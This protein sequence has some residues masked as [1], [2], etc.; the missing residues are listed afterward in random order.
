MKTSWRNSIALGLGGFGG[1]GTLVVS[2][3]NGFP[4]LWFIDVLVSVLI[5]IA[6]GQVAGLI[7]DKVRKVPN[8]NARAGTKPASWYLK[9]ISAS[10]P[11]AD[12]LGQLIAM[13]ETRDI[14]EDDF[15]DAKKRLLNSQG[16]TRVAPRP[17]KLSKPTSAPQADESA[18]SPI[19]LPSNASRPAANDEDAEVVAVAL[20]RVKALHDEGI[21]TDEEYAAKRK[22]LADRL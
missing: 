16:S 18:L 2:A 14:S 15:R 20:R 7:V 12:Q 21:L 22:A 1:L 8:P 19:A 11:L 5:W 10:A 4:R 6:I 9:Q 3:N 13:R 17:E